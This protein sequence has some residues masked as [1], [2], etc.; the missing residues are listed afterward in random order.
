[1][2]ERRH[3]AVVVGVGATAQRAAAALRDGGTTDVAVVDREVIGTVFDVETDTWTLCVPGGE[4]C[5][6]RAVVACE[7][8]FVPWIPNLPGRD[9]G[10]NRVSSRRYPFRAVC[11]LG[12]GGFIVP[13][14]R[15]GR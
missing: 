4:A 14:G 8:P 3:D 2:T 11:A 1:M 9:P 5:H 13:F 15:T 7:S 10:S 6:A 12:A